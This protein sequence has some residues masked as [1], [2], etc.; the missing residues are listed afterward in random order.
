MI[1]QLPE[2]PRSQRWM[3]PPK[4][5]QQPGGQLQAARLS[6]WPLHTEPVHSRGPPAKQ[7]VQVGCHSG[8]GSLPLPTIP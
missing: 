3:P 7:A 6:P 8:L 4:Q 1:Q 5:H 2:S